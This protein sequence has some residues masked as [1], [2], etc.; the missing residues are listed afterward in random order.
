MKKS[1]L[2]KITAL[3]LSAL[4][5]F[6]ICACDGSTPPPSHPQNGAKTIITDTRDVYLPNGQSQAFNVAYYENEEEVL[7][8]EIQYAVTELLSNFVLAQSGNT[9]SFEENDT[10]VFLTRD[11][12]SYC[13]LDFVK[14]TVCFDNFDSFSTA[15][16]SAIPHDML[17]FPY[18][19]DEG[20]KE[21]FDRRDSF[22]TPGYA[23]EIDL[24]E[25]NIPLDIYG[26]KKY[27]PLQTFNDIFL[28]P[29]GCNIAYN[30]E[31][32]FALVGNTIEDEI[33]SLYYAKESAQRSSALTE[34]NYNE[35]CLFL[36]LYYG[37]QDVHGF[38]DGFDYYLDSIGLKNEFLTPDATDSFNALGSLTLGY[39]ADLHSTVVGASPYVGAP[40]PSDDANI[41]L[42]S[43]FIDYMGANTIY[44]T[45]R[46]NALGEVDFYQKVGDTAFV[47]FDSFTLE[48]SGNYQDDLEQPLGDTLAIISIAHQLISADSEIKNVVLDLSCNG[49]G[50]VDSAI[51]TVAWM[52]G[53]CDFSIYDSATGSKGSVCYKA[54][55]NFDH[56]FDDNDTI[57]DKNLY[58]LVSPVSFSCGN[59]VPALLKASSKVT[60]VGKTSTGGGCA[61]RHGVTADGTTFNISNSKQFATVKN[62]T[63]Y[64][65][66]HGVEPDIP[67]TKI[68][69]FYD[70]AGLAEYLDGLK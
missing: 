2:S 36:D 62:G 66:D 27:I 16:Y 26:G 47:T 35:L 52:L 15:G 64:S 11:N 49:G 23:I 30:G 10:Q 18:V 55:V 19:N 38:T 68:E 45:A 69:S 65:V 48:R 13:E 60:I 5:V 59:L 37:L 7:L 33:A 14:D 44:N 42:S 3:V 12:E 1:F 57:K 40:K 34:F 29:F 31:N 54:D 25:R 8:V 61:V 41:K 20:Q 6:A 21:Y 24:A 28:C 43:S 67:L 4:M 50:A 46:A 17:A 63:Y 22:Y 53:Y 51:Y 58:C 39:I 32:L 70:R 9:I 56:V